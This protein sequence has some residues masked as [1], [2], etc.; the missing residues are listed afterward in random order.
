MNTLSV[1][2]DL[3]DCYDNLGQASMR[4]R[5]LMLAAAA[6]LQSG[7]AAEAERLRLRLLQG[8][9]HH[10]L[11]PYP[12]FVEAVK[13]SEVQTYLQDL[14]DNYPLDVAKQ[15]LESVQGNAG[16][17]GAALEQTQQMSWG[18]G[19]RA[20]EP[21][22]A[23]PPTAPVVEMTGPL[24]GNLAGAIPRAPRQTTRPT[25][26]P[27]TY[28]LREEQ[29]PAVTRPLAQPLAGRSPMARQNSAARP[30]SPTGAS[31]PAAKVPPS[32]LPIAQPVPANRGRNYEPPVRRPEA[33]YEVVPQAETSS[34]QE[35]EEPL[36]SGSWFSMLLV[37]VVG[38]VGMA[39]VVFTLA[40]PF[41]PA[42]WLP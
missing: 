22:R 37:A 20:A 18:P 3:A 2:R 6:A 11:H 42:G 4:D 36:Q 15:L 19:E 30:A 29:E 8:N 7:Q 12:S 13:A 9:L 39:L 35:Y 17:S 34:S 23:I 1:Y 24:P 32:S 31:I 26:P 10:M 27:E 5:F 38:T 41:L 21:K 28:P 33:T 14:R 40:R 25:S 16:P